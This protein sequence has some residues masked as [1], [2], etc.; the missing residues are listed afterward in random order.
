MELDSISLNLH[1]GSM[2]LDAALGCRWF[3]MADLWLKMAGYVPRHLPIAVF[4]HSFVVHMCKPRIY[5]TLY[6]FLAQVADNAAA[7]CQT[8]SFIFLAALLWVYRPGCDHIKH[9]QTCIT[10]PCPIFGQVVLRKLLGE[11]C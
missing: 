8:G 3:D 2:S 11:P 10:T 1:Q 4:W 6:D 5:T 7:L 9:H